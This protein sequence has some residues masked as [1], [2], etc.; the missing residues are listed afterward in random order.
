MV[1]RR[2]P[3][4][5][6][7]RV[8]G[9]RFVDSQDYEDGEGSVDEDDDA[10]QMPLDII[11]RISVDDGTRQVI[12]LDD[13][14]A[15]GDC[16]CKLPD[17]ML[18]SY[19]HWEAEYVA[20]RLLCEGSENKF[21]DSVPTASRRVSWP[22]VSALSTVWCSGAIESFSAGGSPRVSRRS[23]S[24]GSFGF[25][26]RP[27]AV[28]GVS[29][30]FVR[31]RRRVSSCD[32]RSPTSQLG[33]LVRFYLSISPSHTID[34]VA[35]ERESP[36]RRAIDRMRKKRSRETN[37]HSYTPP[38]AT[39]TRFPGARARDDDRPRSSRATT[40]IASPAC[41]WRPRWRRRRSTFPP[42]RSGAREQ[43][44]SS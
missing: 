43:P 6:F 35:L 2:K 27:Y 19:A 21:V 40:T 20:K 22:S 7:L 41:P 11:G 42:R 9:S 16:A 38:R 33:L 37:S 29:R 25:F 24:F 17:Q 3:N 36:R 10:L 12:G 32:V 13:V 4:T 34:R 39:T 31:N 15:V 14:Y 26:Q 18:A 8:K 5:D 30:R 1:R 28:L 23:C 44:P